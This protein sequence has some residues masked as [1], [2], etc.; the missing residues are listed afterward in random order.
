M[1]NGHLHDDKLFRAVHDRLS[2]YEVPYDGTDW[3]AMSRS[4]D[5]MPKTSRFQWKFSLNTLFAGL[6]VVGLS[7]L[8]YALAGRT[9][10]APEKLIAAPQPRVQTPGM[11]TSNMSMT[12]TE[13]PAAMQP[14][15]TPSPDAPIENAMLASQT[16]VK[17]QGKNKNSGL[18]FGDQIDRKKGFIYQTQEDQNL[19]ENFTPKPA[20]YYD[21]KDGE[22][23]TLKIYQDST[24]LKGE[25]LPKQ[26][27]ADSA[28][29]HSGA[30]VD[31]DQHPF[32]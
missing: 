32:D 11:Q 18:L 29:T 31:T 15:V 13:Q 25:R 24:G 3:D 30:P 12:H 5:K 1:E 19:V 14:Q 27:A 22:I 28:T 8:G 7:V 10:N 2:D 21:I 6:A 26:I 4:L 9:A 16:Q 23:K 17:K 20:P